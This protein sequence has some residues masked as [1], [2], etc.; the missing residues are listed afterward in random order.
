M[1][2]N[3]VQPD[4]LVLRT[5]LPLNMD[6]RKKVAQFCNVDLGSVIESKDVDTIYEVPLLM[7]EEKLDL[8]ILRK[9]ALGTKSEPNLDRWTTF[10][11]KLKNPK[12][13]IRVGLVGKYVELP[14]SYK[15]IQESFIHAGAENECKVEVTTIHSEDITS[16]NVNETMKD[17]HGILIA[18]GFGQRGIE[19]KII[20]AKYARENN[21]P[22]L[23]VCLGMQC[24]VIEF[25]RNVLGYKEADSTEFNRRTP[26]PVIDLME[27]QKNITEK[28][29]TM[30]LGSYPCEIKKNS[31]VHEIYNVSQIRERHRHRYEFNNAY[32][33]D[34]ERAGMIATGINPET[35]LVEIVEIPEHRWFVG[36]QFHPEYKSTVLQP[37]P[38]FVA[39]VKEMCRQNP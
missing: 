11:N 22:F 27:E 32:L 36:V 8:T 20:A 34:F 24:S 31:N 38:L 1:L 15:S 18:P 39:F 9:L 3:G 14:D 7:K 37:H 26:D 23:G 25:A 5:E 4:A 28:G 29:G 2:E 10:V 35:D 6:I 16:D 13:Q 19:G 17:L 12:T 33:K 21:L 30:R